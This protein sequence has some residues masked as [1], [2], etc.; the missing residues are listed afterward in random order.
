MRKYGYRMNK[1]L[2]PERKVVFG[3]LAFDS[4]KERMRLMNDLYR[5]FNNNVKITVD[6]NILMYEYISLEE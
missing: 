1:M 5:E 3:T 6:E 4:F 2:N